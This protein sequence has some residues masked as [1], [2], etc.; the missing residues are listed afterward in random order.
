MAVSAAI[1]CT[2]CGAAAATAQDSCAACGGKNVRVCSGCSFHNSLSKSYC[3]RCGAPLPPGVAPGLPAA[4]RR[5]G[6]P[7]A[8]SEISGDP[9]AQVVAPAAATT[10]PPPPPPRWTVLLRAGLNAVVVLVSV[11]IS[12]LGV[13]HWTESRKPEVVASHV[14][15][16]YLDAMRA[17][18]FDAAYDLFS[19]AAK[20]YCT[21][22]E[23]KFSRD[24][25]TWT[26]S[27]LRVAHMEP[28]AILMAY[29]L[30]VAGSPARTDRVLFVRE[31]KQWVRPYNWILMRK[32]EDAFDKGN[33][34][35]GL[36]LAQT[37]ATINQRDPMAR[38]Y[39]CEAAYYRKSKEETARQ[40]VAAIDLAR[41]YPSNLT[42][43]SLYHLHA[44]LADTYK[45]ALKTPDKAIDQFA[46]MLAFPNISPIDQCEILL[47][48]A[49]AYVSMSR[50]G[51]ALA[52]LTRGGPL[53]AR[54]ADHAY[55]E[56]MRRKIGAPPN[57]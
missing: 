31:N 4:G 19:A 11:I 38:G 6:D 45:N 1:L 57:Q 16:K 5:A 30:K 48:R 29:E 52:D 46:Q 47:A 42:L 8:A 32:V 44:I 23:F 17:R 54:R 2:K 39:L 26:W 20:K 40:C 12:L 43:K 9:W 34:D 14:A 50:P 25:S 56:E 18:D 33:A 24:D 49:E 51:E 36:I 15:A 27:D 55:I 7:F 21:L 3:D 10:P 22:E 41:I 37:A 13:W 35:M 28:D 53:C